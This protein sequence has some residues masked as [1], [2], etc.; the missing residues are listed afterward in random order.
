METYQYQSPPFQAIGCTTAPALP[1]PCSQCPTNVPV[2]S[3]SIFSWVHMQICATGKWSPASFSWGFLFF[4]FSLLGKADKHLIFVNYSIMA[5][6]QWQCLSF[7]WHLLVK[8]SIF[9]SVTKEREI[10]LMVM[11]FHLISKYVLALLY[12]RHCPRCWRYSNE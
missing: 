8:A 5:S 12:V 4:C 6:L 11:I 9:T 7:A 10:N 1:Q 3:L 2:E